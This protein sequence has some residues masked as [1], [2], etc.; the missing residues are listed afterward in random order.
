MPKQNASTTWLGLHLFYQGSLDSMLQ[1]LVAPLVRDLRDKRLLAGY[2]FVRH[3]QG[4][5]HVRLRLLSATTDVGQLR[6]WAR[7][8]SQAWLAAHPSP[9]QLDQ[10]A[11]QQMAQRLCRLEPDATDE[12][13]QPNNSLGFCSYVP[14]RHKYGSGEAL[15]AVERHFQESSDLALT[16]EVAGWSHDR[17]RVH[18][19]AALIAAAVAGRDRNQLAEV[20][21]RGRGRWATMLAV[22]PTE[23]EKARRTYRARKAELHAVV[24]AIASP[25]VGA[26]GASFVD[27]WSASVATLAGRLL[28]LEERDAFDPDSTAWPRAARG[29]T[30]FA[31]DNCAHMMCNRLGLGLVDEWLMRSL[32]A[33]AIADLG[34][35][36]TSH[37][38]AGDVGIRS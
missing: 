27:R 20:L 31:I 5:P 25:G 16:S 34:Q 33:W 11:Y 28:A 3:W 22:G 8:A 12:G 10:A 32:A 36:V 24:R 18:A 13:L 21:E 6:E 2:F 9:D 1:G 15:A 38:P 35:E 7:D 23:E 14:E 17:R 4:G 37:H 26:A 29:R 30:W 19:Y